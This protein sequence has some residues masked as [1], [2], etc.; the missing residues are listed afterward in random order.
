VTDRDVVD[1]PDEMAA[2]F[3][4]TFST[5]A[6]AACGPEYTPAYAIQGSGS[7]SPMSGR[8]VATKGVVVGDYEGP[9]PALRGFYLQDLQGDDNAATSD[10]LFVFNSGSD[11]VQLGQVV[12]VVGEVSEFQAQTQIE[13]DSVE[14]C[15]PHPVSFGPTSVTLPVADPTFL[16]RYEGMLVQF[17]QQLTV[18]ETFQLGRFGQVVMSS[19]G[20]QWQPTHLV[21]PGDAAKKLQA[22]NN[23]NRI[24]VDDELQNQN[25]DPILFGGG[26]DPLTASN[27]LRIGDT[28]DDVLGVMTYTWGGNGASPNAYRLRPVN[29]LGG[30]VPDFEASNVR[31]AEPADVGGSLKVASFNVLNYFNTFNDSSTPGDDCRFGV[32][33]GPSDCRG[34]D[35]PVEFERQAAKVVN[36][37]LGLDADVVGL[38]EIENDGY[39]PDSAIQNLTDRL[40]ATA[41]GDDRYAVLDVDHR[42][43]QVNA[44]GT[45]A[46]KVGFIYRPDAVRPVGRTATLNTGAFGD[47]RV[48]T[49]RGVQTIGRSRP[50]VSQAFVER[51]NGGRAVVTVNHLKSKGS[52]CA[53][54]ILPV[55]PDPD[56]GDGQAN[57]NLTRTAAAEELVEW[58][59][60][61]P[62]RINEDDSLIIGDLNAYAKEDPV[63]AIKNGGYTDLLQAYHGSDAYSYVFDG[64]SGYLDHALASE[65]LR[66]Q[67]TG[68]TEWHI[69]ADEPTALDYNTNFKSVGHV[70]SL[71]AP[72]PFRSSDH[73]AVLIGLDLVSQG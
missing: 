5:P 45:D 29:A 12:W 56:T 64:Q 67:V 54:N 7:A 27:T 14:V 17:D 26:G 46:I 16:E 58:L 68:V 60:T 40:N 35:N 36:A 44:A 73:D 65:T 71:Y 41:S 25:R 32:G 8:R 53:N 23:L 39:G 4:T 33:G 30:G 6:P 43:G 51:G 63:D 13:A 42:T 24:I 38:I 10:A 55:G 61:R 48:Q 52:S 21:E 49:S 19:G 20:R 22:E 31:P 59:A 72:D 15:D 66:N 69:N 50:A 47:F 18:T 62:T 37:I 57:C 11:E 34:A 28:A 70:A 9:Q 3:T 2:D 1:P